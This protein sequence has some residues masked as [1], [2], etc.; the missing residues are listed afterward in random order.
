L[1]KDSQG[2][3][4]STFYISEL[5]FDCA[6]RNRGTNDDKKMSLLLNYSPEVIIS[7]CLLTCAAITTPLAE[8]YQVVI[9]GAVTEIV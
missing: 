2:F 1:V 6:C 3:F 7:Y 5:S 9:Q 8:E 4:Q